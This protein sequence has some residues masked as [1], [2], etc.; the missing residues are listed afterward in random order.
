MIQ[1]IKSRMSEND[2]KAFIDDYNAI[3]QIKED[4]P[5]LLK[6]CISYKRKGKQPFAKPYFDI[7]K[8]KYYYK[9]YKEMFL[10]NRTVQSIIKGGRTAA[11][12]EFSADKI[13]YTLKLHFSI[14]TY[15]GFL[16]E[17]LIFEEL[18]NGKNKIEISTELDIIHKTDIKVNDYCY[19]IK[20]YSFINTNEK[21]ESIISDYK[22]RNS[23]LYFIFY[24]PQKENIYFAAVGGLPLRSVNDINGFTFTIP[25]ALIGITELCKA[26]ENRKE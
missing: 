12:D 5:K 23:E 13:E 15:I 18:N 11:N 9:G 25:V 14:E 22:M 10:D 3:M 17:Y 7:L 21:L 19:Q 8:N 4:N 2:Y 6:Y 24:Y 16:I 20:N 26:I 1:L